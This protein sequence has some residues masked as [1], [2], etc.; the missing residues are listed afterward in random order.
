MLNILQYMQTL[1]IVHRDIKP[2]NILIDYNNN[3]KL[4]D[5]GEGIEYK[6]NTK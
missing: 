6:S 4:S 5:I 1:N 2:D 3:I